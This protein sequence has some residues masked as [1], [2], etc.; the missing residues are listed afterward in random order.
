MT[1]RVAWTGGGLVAFGLLIFAAKHFLLGMP[2][3]P[4]Q[5]DDLWRVELEILTRS[6]GTGGVV[7]AQL[8]G[9]RN[10]QVVDDE[11]VTRDRLRFSTTGTGFDRTGAWKGVFSGVHELSHSFR[12]QLSGERTPFPIDGSVEPP[13]L[14]ADR[15]G[16]GSAA[17]PSDDQDVR[18]FL[19]H[20]DLQGPQEPVGRARTLLVFVADEIELIEDGSSD[21][22]L[23][24][25]VREC[26]ALG[27]ERLL[28]TFLRGSGIPARVIQGLRLHRERAPERAAWVEAWIG[29]WVPMSGSANA[30]GRRDESLLAIT[31]RDVDPVTGVGVGALSYRYHAR[32]E[33][34]RPDELAAVMGPS[35]EL[36][37]ALSMYRLPL[38]TQRLLGILLVIP[39]AALLLAGARNLV[40]LQT[41]GTFLPVLLALALRESNLLVGFGML[42]VVVALGWLSRMLMDRLHL[43]LVPR[44]CILLCLVVLALAGL[45]LLGRATEQPGLFAGLLFPIVILSILI[46]RFSIAVA[47]DGLRLSMARL[48]WTVAVTVLL[49]PVFQSDVLA[50]VMFGFPEL[51]VAIIGVLV[52]IGGYT[53]YR[54][55]EL[56]RF[57]SLVATERTTP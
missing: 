9:N 54:L 14:V 30:F 1:G 18:A 23:C 21:A 17:I 20:L 19:L 28:A 49:Y 38:G 46:E 43:L 27:K 45:S 44:L 50:R 25:A 26:G 12:V 7:R 31:S 24:L 51:V 35:N 37:G 8:P 6:V 2:V 32:P 13:Q 22:L 40:G 41:F 48:G 47:E 57:R 33:L 4:S 34:L 5:P 16:R 10:G 36:L 15:W 42:I 55:S 29:G 53:G 39:V 3:M 56:I 52:W 11:H